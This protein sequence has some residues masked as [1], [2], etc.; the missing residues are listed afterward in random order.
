KDEYTK[1]IK[2]VSE[3]IRDKILRFV[4]IRRTRNDV[5]NYFKDDL[6]KPTTSERK[7]PL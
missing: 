3:E 5:K 4:M 1:A 6:R 2:A 7:T